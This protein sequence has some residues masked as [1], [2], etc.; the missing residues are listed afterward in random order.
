LEDNGIEIQDG[1][2]SWEPELGVPTLKGINM[3]AEM[4]QKVA[5]CG[6]V[7]SGK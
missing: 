7:G 3:E 1:N 5:I 6:R 2:Y 4:G